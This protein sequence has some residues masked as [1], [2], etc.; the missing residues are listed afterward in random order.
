MDFS[1]FVITI[2]I[3]FLVT[4]ISFYFFR[5]VIASGIKKAFKE[6]EQE[7]SQIKENTEIMSIGAETMLFTKSG[8]VIECKPHQLNLWDIS[9]TKDTCHL[10][11]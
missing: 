5:S 6:M 3:A 10:V 2:G 4:V 9:K 1:T 7:K 8:I 11:Q